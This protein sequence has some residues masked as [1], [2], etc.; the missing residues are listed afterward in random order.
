MLK[1]TPLQPSCSNQSLLGRTHSV[2]RVIEVSAARDL[3][4]LLQQLQSLLAL[5]FDAL[6]AIFANDEAMRHRLAVGFGQIIDDDFRAL[7]DVSGLLSIVPLHELFSLS[8]S[9]TI[10]VGDAAL[11]VSLFFADE[12]IGA[13]VACFNAAP[14]LC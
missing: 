5:L 8:D 12:E 11:K 7:L 6:V 14:E 13:E 10:V 3:L 4:L 9:A 1:K 2:T